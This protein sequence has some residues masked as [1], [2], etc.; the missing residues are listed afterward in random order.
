MNVL[1]NDTQRL[2]CGELLKQFS[3]CREILR[4]QRLWVEL[5]YA[6]GGFALKLQQEHVSKIWIYFNCAVAK[7]VLGLSQKRGACF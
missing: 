3:K 7:Q 2:A 1:K 4:L 6:F 5:L